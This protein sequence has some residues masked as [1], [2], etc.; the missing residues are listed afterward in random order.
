MNPTPADYAIFEDMKKTF[1]GTGLPITDQGYG[2]GYLFFASRQFD[3]TPSSEN[4]LT[5]GY[6]LKG[7]TIRVVSRVFHPIPAKKTNDLLEI[8][9]FMNSV[10]A[11]VRLN[12]NPATQRVHLRG[13]MDLFG[14]P[15]NQKNF[16]KLLDRF[17]LV[18]KKFF[19]MIAD[20]LNGVRKKE[21]IKKEIEGEI[22][23][24]Q[25]KI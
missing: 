7:K 8:F 16:E 12:I 22:A 10:L 23:S 18:Q 2:D 15:L 20:F 9:N 21:D 19:P 5:I 6:N 11:N 1:G 4:D 14:D 17:F 24:Q 3:S 25:R 13:E